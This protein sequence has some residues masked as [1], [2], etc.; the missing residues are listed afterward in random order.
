MVSYCVCGLQLLFAV[1]H[2]VGGVKDGFDREVTDNAPQRS[3]KKE[4]R[5]RGKHFW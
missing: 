2:Q 4:A 1:C 3:T 5:H